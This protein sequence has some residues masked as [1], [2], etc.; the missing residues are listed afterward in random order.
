MRSGNL[1]PEQEAEVIRK[2]VDVLKKYCLKLK[3]VEDENEKLKLERDNLKSQVTLSDDTGKKKHKS[4]KDNLNRQVAGILGDDEK[5]KI[6]TDS[7][8]SVT[9][10]YG[11]ADLSETDN[12][13]ETLIEELKSKLKNLEQIT[14]ERDMLANKVQRLE[15]ELV[16]YRD[17]PEDIEVYRNRSKMLDSALEER[18]KMSKKIE[19]IKEM[20]DEMNQL[21]KRSARV[22]ELEE[23]LKSFSKND[24]NI[25]SELKKTKSRCTCLEKELQNVK[26]ERDSMRTRIEYMKKEIEMLKGKSKEAEIYKVERDKLQIKANELS[27]IQVEYENLLLKC[28]C[29]ENAAAEREIYKQ[30]YEEVLTMECQGDALRSQVEEAKHMEREKNALV[31]QVGDLES[32][33]CDQEEEIKKLMMQI[34]N[35]CRNKDDNQVIFSNNLFF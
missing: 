7:S 1:S 28:K 29:L 12:S 33:I 8:K 27:H 26:M 31:K 16:Q 10:T 20:E 19:Q 30:K 17:L 2:E 23:E 18:D 5:R 32:C 25:G 24:K 13:K 15:K 4:V 34:D 6:E 35:L 14:R 21:R 22:D 9:E 3:S 11:N